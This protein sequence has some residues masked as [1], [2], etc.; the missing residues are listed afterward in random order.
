MPS[1]H[2]N[3]WI[4]VTDDFSRGLCTRFLR[5]HLPFQSGEG[6]TELR[7]QVSADQRY[8]LSLDGKRL[9]YG[10]DRG[11]VAHWNAREL[12]VPLAPGPHQLEALVWVIAEDGSAL[13]AGRAEQAEPSVAPPMAQMSW[14]GG[15]MLAGQGWAER[16]STGRADWR[17]VDVT[18]AVGLSRKGGLGYHD[19]GPAFEIDLAAWKADAPLRATE[20]ILGGDDAPLAVHGVV[21]PG[22]KLQPSLIPPQ[23][24][25]PYAGGV[26]RQGSW[27]G[28]GPL[29]IHPHSREVLLWDFE[30]YVCGYPDLC[31]SGGKGAV[32]SVEWA[33]SL[34]DPVSG[35]K[36]DA[37]SPKGNRSEIAG[38]HWLGFGDRFR[39]SG[40]RDESPGL[41][42]RAGRYVRV[43]IQ[44]GEDALTLER[45]QVLSTRYPLEAADRWRS[46]DPEWDRLP[47]L[48]RA[49]LEA[50]AH[51]TWADSPYY[52]QMMYVGD[53]RLHAL[54]NYL[55]Y[56][57]DRLSRRALDLLEQ[58]RRES[59]LG[60][61]AERYPSAWRQDSGTYAMMYVWMLRDFL[62]WRDDPRFVRKHIPAMRQL[63]EAFLPLCEADGRMGKVPGWPFVDWV[64]EWHQGCGPGVREGDSAIVSLHWVLTL[65]AAAQ[66]EEALGEEL[67]A[68]RCRQKASACMEA[69]MRRYWSEERACL[70]DTPDSACTSEHA[71]ILALL[72][73]LA[74]PERDGKMLA[75]VE[76]ERL[77]ARCTLYFSFYLLE[78]LSRHGRGEALHRRLAAWR[79]FP[80]QGF[81]TVPEQP[82]PTRSD[83]HAWS[84]HPLF[85][86]YASIAGIRSL[87]PGF[88]KVSVNPL[89]G[90]LRF[91]EAACVHPQGRIRVRYDE[92]RLEVDLPAGVE[93]IIE[94]AN[95]RT[96]EPGD[97]SHES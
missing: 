90:P 53:T 33:E 75:A 3:A 16:L 69:L 65:Q 24:L 82:E 88:R 47:P 49:T 67:L 2:V 9:D 50:G 14:R 74:G 97:V 35:K 29:R 66:I 27:S 96:S 26:F 1:H 68:G 76:A 72:T 12:C 20:V 77:S 64:P 10:P 85:H 54:S 8:Q 13:V 30:R 52:E 91:F 11:D 63:I 73:G 17:V 86:S 5:F 31:W 51:E 55:C 38:K 57:D 39:A 70:L 43:E 34:Y 84:A 15:F 45:V 36:P 25:E 58:S 18:N 95:L 19:I 40:G 42:W 28:V 32:I 23:R 89:P 62:Y 79:V 60:M 44:T 22:W 6:E 92:G 48:F 59:P 7:I 21:R 81:V 4:W 83:C 80:E 78:A 94:P 87:A 56:P 37:F 61:V 41:W 93:R 46:S 71:Q